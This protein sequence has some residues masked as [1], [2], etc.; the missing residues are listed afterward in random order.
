MSLRLL[1]SHRTKGELFLCC[2]GVL[3]SWFIYIYDHFFLC[4]DVLLL[5]VFL[6]GIYVLGVS[7]GEITTCCV[8]LKKLSPRFS[9]GAAHHS[10]LALQPVKS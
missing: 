4:A 10:L 7:Q 1:P 8:E 3:C 2:P 5:F 9:L 6:S